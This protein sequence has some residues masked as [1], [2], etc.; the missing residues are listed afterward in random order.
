MNK[1]TLGIIAVLALSGSFYGGMK[2]DQ[3]K[4]LALTG[5]NMGTFSAQGRQA[6]FGGGNGTTTRGMRGTGGGT[7]GNIVAKDATSITVQIRD[8][9]SRTVFFTGTTPV[10]K[11]TSGSADDLKV[12]EAILVTGTSNQDGSVSAQSIQ[13]RPAESIPTMIKQ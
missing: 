6:G 10:L 11:S 7:A 8:G 13:I 2:Y 1:I 9:G 5:S 3:S 12:G 4:S